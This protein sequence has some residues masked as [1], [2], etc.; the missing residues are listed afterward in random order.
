MI[1]KESL[2]ISGMSCAACAARIEKK[3]NAHPG[4]IQ[5]IVNLATEKATVEFDDTAVT[6]EDLEAE[7]IGLG[8]G[9][10]REE[11]KASNRVELV[12]K[13][14]SCAACS[15]RIEKRL[16][17][18]DGVII[19]S[20]NLATERATI[21][22]DAGKI[23]V[24]DLIRAVEALGYGAERVEEM[25]RDRA[26]EQRQK[27]IRTLK[28]TLIVSAVLASPLILGMIL[29]L[30]PM[31]FP[32]RTDL[33]FLHNEYFQLI[34]ATPIQ[35]IIGYRFYRHAYLALRAKSANMDVLISMGTS[36]A[37][38]Y[39]LYNVFFETVRAG[40]MKNLY[41]ESS[42]IIITL[43]LLGKYFEAVAKGRT[44]EAIKKL[45]GLKPKTARVIRQNIESD[46]PI[47]EVIVGDLVLVRPGEKI[48]VDGKIIEGASSLD[49]SMLT[50]ESM[51]VEK[52]A[53]DLVIGATINKYGSFKFA[54][55]KVGK[56]TVLS[57]II[58]MV[59]DAQGSKAPIQKIADQV[60]GV[61][62]PTVVAIAV[63]TFLIWYFAVGNLNTGIISA[64][65]VLVIACP[66]ALGLA[67][68]TAIMVG[69]GKGAENGILI[70]GGEYLEL[71]YKLNA[72]VLDKTGTLTRGEPQVTDIILFG[73]LDKGEIL[74]LAAAA[75]KGS[76]HPLGAAIYNKGKTDLDNVPDST[77]FEALPGRGVRAEI[78]GLTV[79]LG[80]RK[81]M[82]DIGV[83]TGE[84]ELIVSRLEDS[85]KTAMMMAVDN[86]LTAVL[87]VA[88]TLKEHSR[89]AVAAIQAMGIE[90]YMITGDNERTARAIAREAGITNVLAEVLPEGKAEEV[91]KLKKLG[92]IVA[93]VGDGI[94]DAPALATADIGMAMGTGTDV[95]ME[96]A[97]ITLMRGDLR[98]IST[99][100]KLSRK[101]MMKIRQNMFWAFIY[102]IIGIPFAA[103]GMLNPI[104]AGGAMAFSSVSVVSNSL[105][106][107]RF[108]ADDA[109]ASG[110]GRGLPTVK[111]PTPSAT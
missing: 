51:P 11:T 98:M 48:P 18:L 94:N 101:T 43:I 92:K 46:I 52:S 6:N 2:N 100:I 41:F 9:A 58:K 74:K 93:M 34:V 102:N 83:D 45:M 78:D 73:L 19:A 38:F 21:E 25:P 91:N 39:S 37:Y 111:E 15:A 53:G 8:Y 89:D 29:D 63:L 22:Y 26:A 79:H 55:T 4:V 80:T 56:D 104:I 17:K 42:A 57:Q 5:A 67:T 61:F 77:R 24:S 50:G 110:R 28:N 47:E 95:A 68:P 86:R 49:E 88:D 36:A 72:V 64:V 59:E 82:V 3:L 87:A 106:L 33:S 108:R 13:G 54:A 70:K 35:F 109:R 27:E 66:C 99:A 16:A 105:S 60:A 10:I 44:S 23:Q 62:V 32:L 76:E 84:A 75:E 31:S 7:V 69:T 20:V 14:M 81:L 71:A 40:M 90:V 30:L 103:L 97:D 12:L 96:A 1:Q 85:G 107:K 65:A